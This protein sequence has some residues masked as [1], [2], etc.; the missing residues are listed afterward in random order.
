MFQKQEIFISKSFFHSCN[1]QTVRC[2][3]FCYSAAE[4]WS[5]QNNFFGA[6]FGTHRINSLGSGFD[7]VFIIKNIGT[8]DSGRYNLSI[9]IFQIHRLF[10]SPADFRA[11]DSNIGKIPVIG[12]F[13]LI[14]TV[15]TEN[16]IGSTHAEFFE[17]AA[18]MPDLKDTASFSKR[19]TACDVACIIQENIMGIGNFFQHM[20]TAFCICKLSWF[21]IQ[22]ETFMDFIAFFFHAVI[23]QLKSICNLIKT[24]FNKNNLFR[25]YFSC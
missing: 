21:G 2:L 6:G 11:A 10:I 22:Q 9:C 14:L 8:A 17:R 5:V 23:N 25:I 24:G 4:S 16:Q 12:E 19:N 3:S 15:V 7:K 18:G 13:L 1:I 20:K